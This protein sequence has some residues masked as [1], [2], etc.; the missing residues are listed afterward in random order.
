MQGGGKC[1]KSLLEIAADMHA[2]GTAF[3]LAQHV[4]IT[5]C[6][7]ALDHAKGVAG[8]GY[9]QVPRIIRRNLEEHAGVGASCVGLTCGVEEARPKTCGGGN[10]FGIA[11]M[12]AGV[13]EPFRRLAVA[14]DKGQ[15]GHVV[16]GLD[17]VKVGFED[18]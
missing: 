8:A 11:H 9:G 2:Q 18:G 14:L 15:Q 6:L 7:C 3:A 5:T 10:G 4:K 13:L 12:Q 1:C 16:T 17:T